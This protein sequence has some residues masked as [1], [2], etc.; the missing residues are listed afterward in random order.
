LQLAVLTVILSLFGVG[1]YGVTQIETNY[2]SIWYLR[3]SSYQSHFY[4]AL[5][6]YFPD[7]GE[8]V[9]VYVGTWVSVVQATDHSWYFAILDM[10]V[11]GN[12]KKIVYKNG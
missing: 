3:K 6:E 12:T 9:Q 2:S 10:Y 7:S 5:K 1:L 11:Y 4:S 8:R